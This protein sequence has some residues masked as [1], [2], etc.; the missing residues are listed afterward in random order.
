M[1]VYPGNLFLQFSYSEGAFLVLLMCLWSG[2]EERRWLPAAFGALL[3]PL[4]RAIGVFSVIPI[5][6]WLLKHPRV[7]PRWNAALSRI[8]LLK[9]GLLHCESDESRHGARWLLL[10]VI[11][12][13][14]WSLYLGL[15][16]SWTGNPFEGFEAQK[17]WGRHSILNLVNIPK[18]VLV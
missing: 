7:A 3:L 18:F 15:M 10:L 16:N 13:I 11:P 8:P 1:A 17:T 12:P 2:L 6:F 9:T 5:A 14:G 4:S